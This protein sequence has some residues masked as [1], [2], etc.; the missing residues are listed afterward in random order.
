MPKSLLPVYVKSSEI[1]SGLLECDAMLISKQVFLQ[2]KQI[3]GERS[4]L[5][6]ILACVVL[7]IVSDM[8]VSMLQ[9]VYEWLVSNCTVVLWK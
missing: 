4:Q 6:I 5:C 3:A 2:K 9:G 7:N 8:H 1:A